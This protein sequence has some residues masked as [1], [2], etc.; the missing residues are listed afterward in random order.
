[1]CSIKS[2]LIIV[3]ILVAYVAYNIFSLTVPY[4]GP[5]TNIPSSCHTIHGEHLV[6]PEDLVVINDVI[7][8]G[9]YDDRITLMFHK[10]PTNQQGN[11][12]LVHPKT[13]RA[14]ILELKDFP[15]DIFFHPHGIS[16]YENE[17][18]RLLYVL[19]HA[20]RDVG[21]RIE[22]FKVY[23]ENYE[24]IS[25]EWYQAIAPDVFLEFMGTFNDLDVIEPGKFYITQYQ[26][27][28]IRYLSQ[29][30]DYWGNLKFNIFGML[31]QVS[32]VL[33]L[34]LTNIWFVSYNPNELGKITN[35]KVERVT[36]FEGFLN[37]IIYLPEGNFILAANTRDKVIY[38][39]TID[40][41][42]Y[43]LTK[44]HT[45]PTEIGIDNLYLN[46]KSGLITAGGPLLEDWIGFA[47]SG[48]SQNA[49]IS[50]AIFEIR[51]HPM[52]KIN[53]FEVGEPL[54]IFGSVYSGTSVMAIVDDYYVI[55]SWYTKGIAVCKKK[56]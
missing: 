46:K 10:L 39:Y 53:N 44:F 49:H 17:G 56:S 5:R 23:G 11:L 15:S 41:Q 16:L 4:D 2:L 40:R 54:W 36:N 34:P 28:P 29:P 1:M 22:V 19:N 20:D 18:Q 43:G 52:R 50:G 3:S 8:T 14:K 35:A 30:D 45:I 37:G 24:D 32:M 6:G 48:F 9:T 13:D 21:E 55:G 47:S 25:L 12:H 51:F 42:N 31:N 38:T 27:F 33:R 7:I 26:P